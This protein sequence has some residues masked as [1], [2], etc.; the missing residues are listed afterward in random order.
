MALFRPWI[1]RGPDGKFVARSGADWLLEGLTL[2]DVVVVRDSL[3][4]RFGGELEATVAWMVDQWAQHGQGIRLR[5]RAGPEQPY[6]VGRAGFVAAR[7][8][9]STELALRRWA[10]ADFQG[11]LETAVRAALREHLDQ[12]GL[13]A[14]VAP[15]QNQEDGRE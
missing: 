3:G 11:A 4:I 14:A 9:R 10:V 1:G 7:C 12:L 6:T 8:F 13:S 5:A 2:G 15:R